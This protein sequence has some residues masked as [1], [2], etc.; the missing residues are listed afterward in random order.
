MAFGRGWAVE[1]MMISL[2][3]SLALAVSFVIQVEL[4][5]QRKWREYVKRLKGD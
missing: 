2:T 4:E 1:P 5:E 3:I